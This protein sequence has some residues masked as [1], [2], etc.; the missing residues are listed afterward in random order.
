[1]P[2]AGFSPALPGPNVG[3]APNEQRAQSVPPM[4]GRWR[5]KGSSRHSRRL[6]KRALGKAKNLMHLVLADRREPFQELVDGRTM[7]EMLEERGN[8][9][10]RASKAPLAAELPRAPVNGAAK[11]PIH[12]CSLSLNGRR[13]QSHPSETLLPAANSAA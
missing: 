8:P 6:F 10:P 12:N 9:Q 2:F 7:V 4:P 1:M 3:N 5:K 13:G 11:A